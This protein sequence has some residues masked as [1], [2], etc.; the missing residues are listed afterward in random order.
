MKYWGYMPLILKVLL[1]FTYRALTDAW[2]NFY[3]NKWF[4]L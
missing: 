2:Y 1:G 3:G 4:I